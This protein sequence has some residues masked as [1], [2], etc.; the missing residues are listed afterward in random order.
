MSM[1]PN[2]KTDEK[3]WQGCLGFVAML[4]AIVVGVGS[5]ILS[6][7]FGLSWARVN[8][9]HVAIL[10]DYLLIAAGLTTFATIIWR[11][12]MTDQQVRIQRE[13]V[14]TQI[15]QLERQREQVDQQREQVELLRRQIDSSNAARYIDLLAEG[16]KLLEAEG[17]HQKIAGV[18]IL[19][20]VICGLDYEVLRN[21]AMTLIAS[22]W[23][24]NYKS[25]ADLPYLKLIKDALSEGIKLG[26]RSNIS[27]VFEAPNDNFEWVLVEGFAS[28]SYSGGIIT[29]EN[30]PHISTIMQ[31]PKISF[32]NVKIYN[33]KI[34]TKEATFSDCYFIKCRFKEIRID[35]INENYFCDCDF[36]GCN[37]I[38]YERF[39][40]TSFIS[41]KFK[42][43][44]FIYENIP[45][46]IVL[47]SD[48]TEFT[49]MDWSSFL[50][51]R[52]SFDD[53]MN[54]D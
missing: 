34:D 12:M 41:A 25:A 11:G 26:A 23:K 35:D 39:T 49:S 16:T 24:E 46:L 9:D 13:Q 28:Q 15:N 1:K 44:Y 42:N 2:L 17:A 29:N 43:C 40:D 8:K 37:F 21:P 50:S 38:F 45:S 30:R 10:K 4:F 18:A 48:E 33:G 51:A 20:E 27:A 3:T 22:E 32:R 52:E 6:F 19:R 36:S 14:D 47:T 31:E 54:V 53:F 5:I 7:G